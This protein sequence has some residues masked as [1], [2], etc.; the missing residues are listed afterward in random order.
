[1]VSWH[2]FVL[3]TFFSYWSVLFLL[4]ILLEKKPA[5]EYKMGFSSFEKV[6]HYSAQ[7]QEIDKINLTENTAAKCTVSSRNWRIWNWQFSQIGGYHL[8]ATSHNWRYNFSQIVGF[9]CS[10]LEFWDWFTY[11]CLKYK[12]K[13]WFIRFTFKYQSGNV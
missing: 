12:M 5:R 7:L 4:I 2:R 6:K 11:F 13:L 10:E 9:S 8:V 1:M 3:L